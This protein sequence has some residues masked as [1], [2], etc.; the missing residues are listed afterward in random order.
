MESGLPIGLMSKK[1]TG[2]RKMAVN[3][4][5]CSVWDELTRTLKK[6]K[7]R[8]KPKTTEEAVNP[9]ESKGR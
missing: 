3:M 1:C 8:R 5:L 2:V 6:T 9:E 7:L 4:L